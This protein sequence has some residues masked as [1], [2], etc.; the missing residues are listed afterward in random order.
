M[1]NLIN[2]N[3][4][5]WCDIVFEGKNKSYGA[6]AMR[7]SSTKRHVIAFTI[8]LF[9]VTSVALLPTVINTVKAAT[10]VPNE[11]YEGEYTIT[12]IV[13]LETKLEDPKL[14]DLVLAEPPKIMAEIKFTPP[15]IVE[16]ELMDPEKAM[17]AMTELTKTKIPIGKND[18]LEGSFDRDAISLDEIKAHNVIIESKI[19]EDKPIIIAEV[20]PQFPGGEKEMYSYINQNLKYPAIAQ[21]TGTQGKVTIRFVVGKTGEILNVQILRG[22]DPACDKEALRVVKSM[23]RWIPGRQNGTPVQVYFTLPITFKLNI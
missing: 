9:F 19:E 20:M 13:D 7:Q 12:T 16:D 17:T 21:E 1:K 15:T 18:Y 8:M 3:S 10:S 14:P 2:L 5:E 23:P 11:G 6:Y 22:F 4:T